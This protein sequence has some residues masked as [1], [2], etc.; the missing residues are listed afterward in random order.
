MSGNLLFEAMSIVSA[1]AA[2]I[3][4]ETLFIRTLNYAVDGDRGGADYREVPDT[5][6]LQP[7]QFRTASPSLRRWELCSSQ[8]NVRMFGAGAGDWSV[9]SI[10]FVSAFQWAMSVNG[11]D[12]FVPNG[13]YKIGYISFTL[14]KNLSVRLSERAVIQGIMTQNSFECDGINQ[15]FAVFGDWVSFIDSGH[16][17]QLYN[18][19]DLVYTDLSEGIDYTRSYNIITLSFAPSDAFILRISSRMAIFTFSCGGTLGEPLCSLAWSGGTIDCSLRGFAYDRA[20][21]TGIQLSNI[22]FLR[23]ENVTGIGSSDYWTAWIDGF[24][25]SLISGQARGGFIK[26]CKA[27]GFCDTMM[28]LTGGGSVGDNDDFGPLEVHGNFAF[29]CWNALSFKRQMANV[30]VHSNHLEECEF[31]ITFFP[32][33]GNVYGARGVINGNTFKKI[34]RYCICVRDNKI[35]NVSNNIIEDFGRL[36]SNDGLTPVSGS[37]AIQVLGASDLVISGNSVGLNSWEKADQVFLR[38]GND[39]QGGEAVP[40][41]R[42]SITGNCITGLYGSY[43]FGGDSDFWSIDNDVLSNVDIIC[44][45]G[46]SRKI[47]WAVNYNGSRIWGRGAVV[48]KGAWT[49]VLSF[50][51]GSGTWIQSANSNGSFERHGNFMI[52][53]FRAEG[54]VTHTLGADD[55]RISLPPFLSAAVNGEAGSGFMSR[56]FGITWPAGVQAPGIDVSPNSSVMRYRL[57]GTPNRVLQAQDIPSG[58]GLRFEGIVMY[59]IADDH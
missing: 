23:F 39:I 14:T 45:G 50:T 31:G 21:G 2:T 17:V 25:D 12:I 36:N 11:S 43:Y 33:S 20:S 29:K 28:Y 32:S 37:A 22:G 5:G 19:V 49:P 48:W 27:T 10:A 3:P 1:M 26:G 38:I 7:W 8:V 51:S 55:L 57:N 9:D 54:S 56:V 40:S 15:S 47:L 59:E 18:V 35:S 53:R 58:Q 41:L 34:S 52:A 42:G 44:N 6:T 46:S 30:S 13:N 16:N 4:P 24:S